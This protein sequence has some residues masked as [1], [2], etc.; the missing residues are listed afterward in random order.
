MVGRDVDTIADYDTT[1]DSAASTTTPASSTGLEEE[2]EKE[3]GME[4]SRFRDFDECRAFVKREFLRAVRPMLV[5]EVERAFQVVQTTV[6]QKASDLVKDF[7][8][9][10]FRT[11]QFQEEQSQSFERELELQSLQDAAA[12]G[13]GCVSPD[14]HS[15]SAKANPPA[16]EMP[17]LERIIGSLSDDPVLSFLAAD[18]EFHWDSYIDAGAA[19]GVG[20]NMG[21]VGVGI[22]DCGASSLHDSAY[23][24][25]SSLSGGGAGDGAS[26]GGYHLV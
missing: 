12:Y 3:P 6:V 26:I 2:E 17:E 4:N 22:D 7:Q 10:L 19:V 11:W 15:R 25:S 9:K 16:P 20:M 8:T 24:T 14:A 1:E 13:P 5:A 23:F 18:G 21:I